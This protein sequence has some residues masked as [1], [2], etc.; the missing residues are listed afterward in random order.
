MD[1]FESSLLK[2]N[3][4]LAIW[5]VASAFLNIA[6][7][8]SAIYQYMRPAMPLEPFATKTALDQDAELVLKNYLSL[9]F[10]ELCQKLL[11]KTE[12][13]PGLKR[14]DLALS[15]LANSYHVD[16]ERALNRQ[17]MGYLPLSFKDGT[18]LKVIP[19]YRG[20]ID[21]DFEVIHRFIKQ[22]AY[23]L[24][25]K[26]LFFKIKIGIKDPDLVNTFFLSE[27]FLKIFD[28]LKVQ[29]VA[30]TQEMLLS[31]LL[32]GDYQDIERYL[33]FIQK[34]PL[35]IEEFL[36]HFMGLGSELCASLVIDRPQFSV[37][38]LSDK[39]ALN[40]LQ[41]IASFPEKQKKMAD[42]LFSSFRSD[43][44]K[45]EIIK[46]GLAQALPKEEVRKT[47]VN[48]IVKKID[49]PSKKETVT[50][51]K[52]EIIHKTYV[53]QEGDSLWKISRKF[54]VDID[55]LKK[56]NNLESENLKPGKTLIIP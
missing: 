11:L 46:M 43:Q 44:F 13:E 27:P 34:A 20:L 45:Q 28:A 33:G 53:V 32:K 21:A 4:R 26:G 3:K 16:L 1:T 41:M 37:K 6:F 51:T 29:D 19:I 52:K 24:T 56:A 47:E 7:F 18:N 55:K 10:Q 15:V 5:L 31:I 12:I 42:E 14:R 50:V 22:E 30:I 54:K 48:V 2:K 8:S 49:L 38:T 9:S 40:L 17:H 25:A 39:Q 35:N 23:P 36:T